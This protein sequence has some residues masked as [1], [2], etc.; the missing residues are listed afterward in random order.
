MRAV[1]YEG[2]Y[3]DVQRLLRGSIKPGIRQVEGPVREEEATLLAVYQGKASVVT[4]D[5]P[6]LSNTLPQPSVSST[7]PSEVSAEL[8][9]QVQRLRGKVALQNVEIRNLRVKL[10][11]EGAKSKAKKRTPPGMT[12]QEMTEV[13]RVAAE[14]GVL[15]GIAGALTAKY[16]R[17]K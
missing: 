16:G 7:P 6:P 9:S 8:Q 17:K 12:Q 10:G 14:S 4:E 11:L 13:M 5:T 15:A 3:D 2:P 1:V